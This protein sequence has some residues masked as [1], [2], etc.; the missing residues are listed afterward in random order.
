MITRRDVFVAVLAAG[1]TSVVLLTPWQE[2]GSHLFAPRLASSGLGDGLDQALAALD[3]THGIGRAYV[4]SQTPA[5]TAE[6]LTRE[7]GRRFGNPLKDLATAEATIAQTIKADFAAGRTCRVDGWLL[8]QTECELAGLRWHLH[9]DAPAIRA[10]AATPVAAAAVAP[11]ATPEVTGEAETP[12]SQI[13]EVLNWGPRTTEQGTR[14]NEQPDGH[15]GLWFQADNVPSWVKV[16]IDGADAPT[17]VSERGFTSGLFGD[18]Q[19]RILST[20]GN[21]RIELH[22]PMRDIT[23]LIGEFEVRPMAERAVLP[24]GTHSRVFCPVV[25]WGP[26]S[27]IAGV[28]ANAQPDGSQGMYFTL[29]CAPRNVQLVF[30]EDRLPATRTE[31][32]VTARVPLAHLAVPGKIALKLRDAD[33]GEELPAGTFEI[34]AP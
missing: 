21:Y 22:D 28:A 17:Q 8:S 30:G 9:G 18:T 16:R 5:L 33:S 10:V 19:E 15:S 34:L 6:Q 23:Q 14:F 12:V 31:R 27:T 29:P 24:D 7:L 26:E 3:G 32:G 13:V 1:A 4:E 2:M 25:S 11:A 20:P